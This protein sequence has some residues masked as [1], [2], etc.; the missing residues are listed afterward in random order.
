M[1]HSNNTT[2]EEKV[3]MASTPSAVQ[4]GYPPSREYS[5]RSSILLAISSTAILDDHF[6]FPGEYKED[7]QSAFFNHGMFTVRNVDNKRTR[8]SYLR[9]CV[10]LYLPDLIQD[11]RSAEW[12]NSI[13]YLKFLPKPMIIG[14]NETLRTGLVF[15]AQF[16]VPATTLQTVFPL[17][18]NLMTDTN[19]P[20]LGVS[21]LV[22]D[23]TQSPMQYSAV[24]SNNAV[25][26][27]VK[28]DK[29]KH[30]VA[31]SQLC[32]CKPMEPTLVEIYFSRKTNTVTWKA[33]QD[34]IT[35][36]R[37]STCVYEKVG[38]V[39]ATQYKDEDSQELVGPFNS[40]FKVVSSY[41][42]PQIDPLPY[43]SSLIPDSCAFR[44]GFGVFQYLDTLP[45]TST[46][47]QQGL[48]R[49]PSRLIADQSIPSNFSVT[50]SDQHEKSPSLKQ[51]TT[52]TLM[53]IYL[54]TLSP[55][56]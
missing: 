38:L 7:L 6:L 1:D 26:A 29:D 14:M 45:F 11:L 19:D 5:V 2:C 3:Q 20:R 52:I 27:I 43:K 34:V 42:I 12:Q 18:S 22:L 9:R 40:H 32:T 24:M 31:I 50:L 15:Q 51:E 23:D 33:T 35:G 13:Q 10:E 55:K 53:S 25:Y 8:H 56:E 48:I 46:Y 54:Q 16:V 28:R 21:G 4:F 30:F 17:W 47:T 37:V 49:Y 36:K 44:V 41:E 39:P